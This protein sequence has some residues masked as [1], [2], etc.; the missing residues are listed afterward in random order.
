MLTFFSAFYAM[1]C[2]MAPYLLM[3][4]LIAGI[5]HVYVPHG[6]L[7]AYLGKENFRSVLLATLLGIPLPLCSCGVIPTAVS[8]RR[9]GASRGATI[10]FMIATPQTGVDS[11]IATY[12]MMGLP[13]AILRPVVALLTGLAGGMVTTQFS[14]NEI[15][16]HKKSLSQTEEKVSILQ[17]IKHVFHYSFVEMFQNIGKWLVI[18]LLLGALITVAVPDNFFLTLNLSPIVMML[19]LLVISIPMYVCTMGSIPIAAALMLKGLTPGAALVFLI[20]GPAVSIANMIVIGKTMGRRQLVLYLLSIVSGAL[21]GGIILDCFLPASWFVLP[22]TDTVCHH[23]ESPSMWDI[24]CSIVF[25]L[26]LCNAFVLKYKKN[27][28]MLNDKVIYKVSGLSC[29]HCKM[30]VEKAIRQLESVNNVEV[31][32]GRQLVIVSGNPYESDLKKAVED[33][34]FEYIGRQ[35]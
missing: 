24:L 30:S 4:F 17:Q 15:I 2:E 33:L 34:G 8:L 25:L 3:G 16:V 19:L 27:K 18:G 20:A 12:S 22:F 32:I 28:I 26:L 21:L 13:F 9:D 6:I 35:Y 11:I 7:E 1:L 31:D 14:K 23:I 10:A 5:L 29:N